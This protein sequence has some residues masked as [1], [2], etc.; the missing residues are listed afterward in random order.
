MYIGISLTIRKPRTERFAPVDLYIIFLPGQLGDLVLSLS[1]LVSRYEVPNNT[2]VVTRTSNRPITAVFKDSF[3]FLFFND[4]L[5]RPWHRFS[6]FNLRQLKH[7]NLQDANAKIFIVNPYTYSPIAHMGVKNKNAKAISYSSAGAAAFSKHMLP[8][9]VALKDEY[10][11]H[12]LMYD[13]I[14]PQSAKIK[15]HRFKSVSLIHEKL[16]AQSYILLHLETSRTSKDIDFELVRDFVQRAI[17]LELL[18]VLTGVQLNKVTHVGVEKGVYDFRGKT[19]IDD[20]A[21]L[22][23]SASYVLSADTVT[24]HLAKLFNVKQFVIT[25]KFQR[26]FIPIGPQVC[27]LDDFDDLRDCL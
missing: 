21:S 13:R 12:E 22:V 1:L 19:T 11:A 26:N 25:K 17:A 24:A 3:S 23:Q 5:V 2:L 7:K 16:N 27:L 10:L 15:S 20:L 14:F 6:G 8:S 4:E 18:V 9:A